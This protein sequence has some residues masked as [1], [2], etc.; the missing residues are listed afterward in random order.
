MTSS[1]LLFHRRRWQNISVF[2]MNKWTMIQVSSTEKWEVPQ[3]FVLQI[4]VLWRQNKANKTTRLFSPK[5]QEREMWL[6]PTPPV[7]PSLPLRKQ[8]QV[9]NFDKGGGNASPAP[10]TLLVQ[11]PQLPTVIHISSSWA[12]CLHWICPHLRQDLSQLLFPLSQSDF[13]YGSLK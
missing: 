5:Y 8:L 11:K 10:F 4:F 3:I 1:Y 13:P 2:L 12:L 6:A 9:S 7:P